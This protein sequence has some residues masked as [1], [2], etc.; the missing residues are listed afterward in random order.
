LLLT[1]GSLGLAAASGGSAT[2]AP[3]GTAAKKGKAAPP[4]GPAPQDSK[5]TAAPAAAPAT[6]NKA[7]AASTNDTK[8]VLLGTKG[9]PRGIKERS[10]PA[11]VVIASGA[12]YVVDC[13]YGVTRQ[14]IEAGIDLQQIRN[15][16]L[17]NCLADRMM[18]LGPLLYCAW[19]NG[20]V[21][22]VQVWGPPPLKRV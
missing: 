20:M 6:G 11:N 10:N 13:G 15:V 1:A 16:F 12:P 9:D 3:A 19:T 17:T 21:Q 14:L 22:P 2:A 7:A 4:A 18:E 5:G 8:A